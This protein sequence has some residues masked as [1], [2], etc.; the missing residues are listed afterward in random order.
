MYA[1][2]TAGI[3][4]INYESL[5][6]HVMETCRNASDYGEKSLRLQKKAEDAAKKYED[7]FR[8]YSQL[9]VFLLPS[10]VR[11]FCSDSQ[12]TSRKELTIKIEEEFRRFSLKRITHFKKVVRKLL[13]LPRDVVLRVTSVEQGCVEMRFEIV[14][15]FPD[16]LLNLNLEQKKALVAENITLMEYAEMMRYCCCE[17][18]E[19]EV[20]SLLSTKIL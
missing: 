12:V 11:D 2:V 4:F 18:L 5:E 1:S 19:D 8:E 20:R 7:A 6:D 9:R 15:A 14:G 16:E 17:L 13:N 10:S 3:D